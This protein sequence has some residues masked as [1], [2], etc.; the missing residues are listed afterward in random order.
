MSWLR[1]ERAESKDAGLAT[2]ALQGNRFDFDP[3]GSHGR[4]DAEMDDARLLWQCHANFLPV[5]TRG[6]ME[7]GG[8]VRRE[9]F[10]LRSPGDAR[11]SV[12]GIGGS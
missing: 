6:P 4:N 1:P 3:G 7:G 10:R 12:S 11:A 5:G 9:A 2:I 8:L